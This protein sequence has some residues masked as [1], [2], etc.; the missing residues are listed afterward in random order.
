MAKDAY[1]IQEVSVTVPNGVPSRILEEAI[2]GERQ[3]ATRGLIAGV[4]VI[5][6]GAIL[7][8]LGATGNI[9]WTFKVPG[10]S[11]ELSNA[12]PGVV[13]MILGFLIIW[14]TRFQVSVAHAKAK[15]RAKTK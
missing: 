4:A 1:R 3:N 8:I 2:K 13:A 9:G 15:S 6:I 10:M 12:S 7:V 11:S 5:L 14:T